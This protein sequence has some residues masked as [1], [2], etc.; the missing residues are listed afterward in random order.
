MNRVSFES[1][2][3]NG[4]VSQGTIKS[5]SRSDNIRKY[6]T[7]SSTSCEAETEEWAQQELSKVEE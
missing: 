6:S 4:N 5:F 2:Q 3:T 7:C 1:Q